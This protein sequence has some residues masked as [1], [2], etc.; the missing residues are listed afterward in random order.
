MTPMLQMH[1]ERIRRTPWRTV[2]R[3]AWLLLLG[4]MFLGMVL[5]AWLFQSIRP[6]LL[7]MPLMILAAKDLS[8]LPDALERT[9]AAI[10]GRD[11][12]RLPSA[13][14][15]PELVGLLRLGRAQRQ[16]CI[17]WLLRRPP[18]APPAGQ[19]FGYLG[20]GAYRTAF[21]IAVFCLLVELPL[22]AAIVAVLPVDPD[23][24][25]LLHV[26]MT[27]GGIAALAWVLGDRWLV[28]AGCHALDSGV[29]RLRVGA[30]AAGDIPVAAI[31]DCRRIDE[32]VARWCA[33]HGVDVLRTLTVSPFDRP[34]AVLVLRPGERVR[35]AHLGRERVDIDCVFVYLDRPAALVDA[36]GQ[37]KTAA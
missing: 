37:A 15:P 14:L 19:A 28:G 5:P 25:R 29:L 8:H 27:M 21:A 23:K 33:R 4:G 10:G 26:L 22:D 16:G 36:I 11:W 31:A 18:P 24:R 3:N 7:A 1:A 20:L 35:L 2:L 12:I 34:N 17:A 9:R 32:P 13:W 6:L 30:R